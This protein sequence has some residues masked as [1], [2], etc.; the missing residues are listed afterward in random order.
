[1]LEI[2]QLK[3]MNDKAYTHGQE[4]R[5]MASDDLVF[6]HV[7]QWDDALLGES[8]LQYR[9]EFDVLRKAGRHIMSALRNNPVSIDF[10][11]VDESREDGAELL[12]GLYRSDSRN[13]QSIEAFE[14]AKSDVVVCGV[15][16]WLLYTEYKSSRDGSSHQ[17]IR[18]K[19]IYEAV[20]TVFYDPN[21]K[22]LDKSDAKY[23]CVLHPFSED[24]YKDLVEELTG[25]R[26]ETIGASF[27]APSQSYAFPWF[28]DDAK[29]YIVDFYHLETVKDKVITLSDPFGDEIKMLES[30]LKDHM[31]ELIDSGYTVDDEKVIERDQV[32][33][34]IASGEEILA[35]EVIAGGRIPVIP[36]YG[37]RAFIEGVEYYEGITRLAKD[38][39]RLRNFQLSYLADI[40]S[41]SPRPKPIFFPEQIQGF[42]EMYEES[43]S[44]NNFPYLLQNS[45]DV[46]GMPLPIGPTSQMPE[47]TIPQALV[48]SIALSR[49]AVE[50]V[51]NPG[52]P[53]NITDPDLSG[54]AMVALNN[55]M[56]QQ[57]MIYQDNFKH[58]L[59]RDAEVYAGMATETHDQP[60]M[61]TVT[62][63]DGTKRQ[64][65]IME[66]II[67]T[68]TGEPLAVNDITNMEFEVFAEISQS[69][70]T[71]KQ[72][73]REELMS[74]VSM[75]GEGDPMRNM[76][77]LK[78]VNMFDGQ[79]FQDVREYANNQLILSGF[80]P[81]E[82]PEEEELLQQSQQDQEPDAMMVAA[83]A[84]DKKSMAENKKADNDGFR[85]RLESRK[86][87]QAEQKLSTE[88][89]KAVSDIRNTDAS[90][91]KTVAETQKIGLEMEQSQI[92][93]LI[94]NLPAEQL[95]AA[96][97]R[98]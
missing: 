37:E 71:Q 12:D 91:M 46:N 18:R 26:P 9:G 54:K 81:P 35:S 24:G 53:Q 30:T 22:L 58:A 4:P 50:D 86:L 25:T 94:N 8:Q 13:N 85:L 42:E 89:F 38:P 15:A 95:Q 36:V 34:Y 44:D 72:Q 90:T 70:S 7:T 27:S 93:A 60:R 69:Y 19:P 21:A 43:G 63:R 59:R 48:A 97:S 49:E 45:K 57:S 96:L 79:D 29:I 31:D 17:V 32:T 11:P 47:Q 65:E 74:L 23:A 33:K 78:Y 76:L 68:D 62:G 55:R 5:E 92:D 6:Y 83:M 14:V 39:Q 10:H 64:V 20:N 41:R 98:R 40:V 16:A 3:K 75:M 51:A 88:Q 80:K 52:L 61:V 1:M 82:T 77:M 66:T 2:T 84:E 56:D 87:D 73:D 67:D 28:S